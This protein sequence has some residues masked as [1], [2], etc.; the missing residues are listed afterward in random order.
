M[1]P[2]RTAMEWPA[3]FI[4]SSLLLPSLILFCS[5]TGHLCFP[6]GVLRLCAQQT[7]T[8]G[9]ATV[10]A[11][12][13]LMPLWQ[14]QRRGAGSAH[15]QMNAQLHHTGCE[16]LSC[17]MQRTSRKFRFTQTRIQ[18]HLLRQHPR[19]EAARLLPVSQDHPLHS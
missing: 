5:P 7:H 9:V 11:D 8:S 15:M 6:P 19:R 3:W 4:W 13:C 12:R 2:F 10:T 16:R 1:R 17:Y 18:T 14:S